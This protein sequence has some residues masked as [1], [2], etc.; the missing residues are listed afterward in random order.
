MTDATNNNAPRHTNWLPS[1]KAISGGIGGVLAYFVILG[2]SY[3][4]YP[5]PAELQASIPGAITWLIY[6]LV[7][8]SEKDIVRNLDNKIVAMAVVDPN[9]PVSQSAIAA[10]VQANAPPILSPNDPRL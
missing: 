2:A 1:R 3:A 9:S 6:Y 10:E 7:P 8:A 4:G 5:I